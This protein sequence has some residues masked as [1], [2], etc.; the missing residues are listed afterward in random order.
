M[1]QR[2]IPDEP[3]PLPTDGLEVQEVRAEDTVRLFR[4]AWRER[5][6]REAQQ[7]RGAPGEEVRADSPI[8]AA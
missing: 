1:R 3:R 6:I 8:P 5:L 2:W 7:A 4:C